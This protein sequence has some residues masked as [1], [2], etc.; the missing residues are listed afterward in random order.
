[1][2]NLLSVAANPEILEEEMS[3]FQYHRMNSAS[4]IRILL[5]MSATCIS[6]NIYQESIR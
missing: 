4:V 3:S 1:M 5:Y 2:K 6:A